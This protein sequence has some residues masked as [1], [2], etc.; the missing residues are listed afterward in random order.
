MR[1]FNGEI[2]RGIEA[3][4]SY[5]MENLEIIHDKLDMHVWVQQY[6][7]WEDDAQY[8]LSCACGG[9]RKAVSKEVF[10]KAEVRYDGY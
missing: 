1:A 5:L 9:Q 8:N 7:P 3:Q 2:P 6:W 4:L 10:D